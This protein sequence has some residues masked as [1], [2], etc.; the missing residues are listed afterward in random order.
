MGYY[1]YPRLKAVR[2]SI[3]D[4]RARVASGKGSETARFIDINQGREQTILTTAQNYLSYFDPDS[5]AEMGNT[6]AKIP[7]QIPVLTVIGN[8]DPLMPSVRQ[9]FVD[10]L[11]VNRKSQFIQVSGGHLDTPREAN[12]QVIDWIKSAVLNP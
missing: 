11:P 8:N 10:K 5:D 12:S 9:Y 7:A 6:A 4:A 1:T 3:D 2:D